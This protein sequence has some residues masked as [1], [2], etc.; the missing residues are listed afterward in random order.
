MFE[1]ALIAWNDENDPR[2]NVRHIDDNG[3]SMEEF[4]AILIDEN[5]RHGRTRSSG[6]QTA[7]GT[8]PDG[9]EITILY[10][11][12]LVDRRM[13]IR[14]ITAYEVEGDVMALERIKARPRTAEEVA[15][16]EQVRAKFGDRPGLQSL[17]DRGEIDAERIMT[18][19]AEESLLKGLIELKRAR[20]DRGLSLTEIS[21]R[22]GIDLTSLSRLEAGK[23]PNPTFE[24][25]SRHADALGL[26]LDLS[27][28]ESGVPVAGPSD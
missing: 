27:F 2:G 28:V 8:L 18:L 7:W 25:L 5:S 13:V 3:I 6:R 26:R 16:E 23:N 15:E 24:T 12:E 11:V 17:I 4:E 20:Q 21:R 9:R 19:A 22:S 10:E 1:D 14:R